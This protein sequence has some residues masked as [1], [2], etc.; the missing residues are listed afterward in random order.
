MNKGFMNLID[1]SVNIQRGLNAIRGISGGVAALMI[2]G[3]TVLA[4][5][6]APLVWFFDLDAT[7]DYAQPMID[8]MIPTLPVQDAVAISYI[9][10]GITILP[11]VV[12]LLL[13][14]IGANVQAAA[15]LV[16]LF[17]AIDAITDYPRVQ[18]VLV[19]YKPAF[20]TYGVAG[21]ALWYPLHLVILLFAT[22]LF[23]LLF[24]LCVVLILALIL[25]IAVGE[26][27]RSTT[28]MEVAG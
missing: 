7:L 26:R 25:R 3:L 6:L 1:L 5:G 12:E 28:A 27:T 15:F 22:F 16:F 24:V 11:T 21:M 14:R 23:E 4:C 17:S 8:Q 10:L 18:S 20:E 13:P 2:V 19:A 9:V